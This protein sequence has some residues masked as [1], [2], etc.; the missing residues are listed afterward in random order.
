MKSDLGTASIVGGGTSI[1]VRLV[2]KRGVGAAIGW[3]REN[4]PQPKKD[5]R[6]VD[7]ARKIF[8]SAKSWNLE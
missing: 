4:M 2:A 7:S 6:A 8:A 5:A 3:P 1:V